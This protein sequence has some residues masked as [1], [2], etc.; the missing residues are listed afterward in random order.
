MLQNAGMSA[1]VEGNR[2]V[3]MKVLFDQGL[4]S[5]TPSGFCKLCA[6]ASSAMGAFRV[7]RP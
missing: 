2:V 1:G 4:Y 7:D 6:Y 3:T 5:G